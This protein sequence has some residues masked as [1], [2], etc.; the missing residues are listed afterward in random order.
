[1]MLLLRLLDRLIRGIS[2]RELSL[3]IQLVACTVGLVFSISIARG[4]D[5]MQLP[6][7]TFKIVAGN[8][9]TLGGK[10][11]YLLFTPDI[12]NIIT[13]NNDSL[14]VVSNY[15]SVNEL[16]LDNDDSKYK[17]INGAFVS[18]SFFE[19]YPL[20]ITSG[21]V[22]KK[23]EREGSGSIL[24]SNAVANYLFPKGGAVGRTIKIS[25]G[26]VGQSAG[27]VTIASVVGIYEKSNDE[28]PN[29][30]LPITT[31][32]VKN[33][34]SDTL[35]V[36]AKSPIS[37]DIIDSV[38]K[39]I[40]NIYKNDL[41][42]TS[43]HGDLY[44]SFDRYEV[45]SSGRIDIDSLLVIISATIASVVTL[46]GVFASIA[47]RML[48]MSKEISIRRT[49]GATWNDIRNWLLIHIFMIL[50]PA[51]LIGAVSCA[52][53]INIINDYTNNSLFDRYISISLDSVFQALAVQA[54]LLVIAIT[55]FLKSLFKIGISNLI[56]AG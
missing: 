54:V 39:D 41:N 4:Q 13:R 34:L 10:Y 43:S 40:K 6:P 33:S 37:R 38:V 24:L 30:L 35:I 36:K 50:I 32:G 48:A 44:V 52:A 22:F 14:E 2:T 29:F 16:L 45:I 15:K 11:T 51:W 49:L 21:S 53:V 55:Y 42:F 28:D 17:V 19:I 20:K 46:A 18:N 47:N 7:H 1:M 3:F 12:E 26:D 8:N 25:Y 9:K 31:L 56:K 23:S 27:E 5:R